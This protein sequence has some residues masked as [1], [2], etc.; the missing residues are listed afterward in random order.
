M[1]VSSADS[2]SDE[3]RELAK[4]LPNYGA[5]GVWH[6]EFATAQGPPIFF[7]F[8]EDGFDGFVAGAA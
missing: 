3:L 5:Y 7:G 4:V 8:I 2:E 1:D 6:A